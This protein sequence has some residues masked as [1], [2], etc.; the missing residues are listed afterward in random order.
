MLGYK[1]KKKGVL[2]ELNVWLDTYIYW[3]NRTN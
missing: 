2:V 3:S 1:N